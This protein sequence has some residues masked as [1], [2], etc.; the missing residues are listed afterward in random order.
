[1]RAIV[2]FEIAVIACQ[3]VASLPRFCCEQCSLNVS[4]HRPPTTGDTYLPGLG[5]IMDAI[6]WRAVPGSQGRDFGGLFSTLSACRSAL[7]RW[8]SCQQV[9][10]APYL[11]QVQAAPSGC[12]RD[13][14][15]ISSSQAFGD[16]AG[17]SW[18][19]SAGVVR[20][21]AADR[22]VACLTFASA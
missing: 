22:L 2:A 14:G 1:L 8:S 16:P 3:E 7:L 18:P 13:M 20:F 19:P 4:A 17:D 12:G 10:K 6:Q 9:S 5:D 21:I 11:Q 15:I